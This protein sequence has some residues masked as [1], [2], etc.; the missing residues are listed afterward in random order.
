MSTASLA[1]I[2]IAKNEEEMIANCLET[3]QW[4]DEILVVNNH[5]SDGT[6]EIAQR[7]GAKVSTASGTFA[8]LRNHALTK[9]KT[10]WI[11]Y[12]D[13]DE[14]VTPALAEEIRQVI[15][16]A[17]SASSYLIYRK[18]ILYGSH[19]QHGGWENDGVVR[20]FE[21]QQLKQWSGDVHEHAEVEG[22]QGTLQESL[23]HFTHRSIVAGLAKTIEWTPIEAE[24]L[25]RAQIPPVTAWTLWR[26]GLMEVWRRAIVKGGYKDGVVGWVE[27][28]VQGMNRV[29]VYMQVWEKQQKPTLSER[30]QQYEKAIHKL[31]KQHS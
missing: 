31:W 12:I 17:D 15:N 30:Y 2:V 9:V 10:D 14:R 24:L 1:A 27:A 7:L 13:A 20:L 8:D 25:Y 18:N 3:L 21:R 22:A 19:L 16:Q 4:C 29:L 11:L 6:V 26:K 28:L 5:S 23:V